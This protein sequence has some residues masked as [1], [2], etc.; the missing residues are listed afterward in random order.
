MRPPTLK[1]ARTDTAVAASAGVIPVIRWAI[2][3]ACE[4]IIKPLKAPQSSMVSI[5]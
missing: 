5:R 2:G 1:S 3:E 4:V